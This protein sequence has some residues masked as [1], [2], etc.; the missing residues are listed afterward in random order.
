[1]CIRDSSS[2]IRV[3]VVRD[4]KAATRKNI[5]GNTE[6]IEPIPSVS[7]LYLSLIHI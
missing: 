3:M 5:T 1:M 4:T 6:P 7:L 2:T